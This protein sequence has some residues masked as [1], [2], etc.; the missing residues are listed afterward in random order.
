MI[1]FLGNDTEE[2]ARKIAEERSYGASGGPN[3]RG[4][5]T[6]VKVKDL[7]DEAFDEFSDAPYDFENTAQ[8]LWEDTQKVYYHACT[9]NRFTDKYLRLCGQLEKNIKELGSWCI[10]K[11]VL[12]H[13]GMVFPKLADMNI[14]E[15]VRMVSFHLRKVHAALEG[16]Y[17][18]NN[19]LGMAYLDWE[20]RWVSLG[21]R[22]KATEVKIQKIRDGRID[23]SDISDRWSVVGD[24][25]AVDGE[26]KAETGDR[27][28]KDFSRK[29]RSLRLNPMALPV[30]RS[31]VWELTRLRYEGRLQEN[32]QF[33]EQVRGSSEGLGLR[34]G[35]FEPQPFRPSPPIAP[36]RISPE[37]VIPEPEEIPEQPEAE[38]GM[39]TEAEARKILIERAMK[40]GDMK[41][42][43]EIQMEDLQTF[44]ARWMRHLEEQDM[45]YAMK[46]SGQT[47]PSNDTRK[48]LREKRKKRK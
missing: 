41:T 26:Q 9:A 39:L 15:L 20:L 27:K 14:D 43:M 46:K 2:M 24:Q 25:R 3:C 40:A 11:A 35:S 23:V 22:L 36:G 7:P 12:E 30:K 45:Q 44:H 19:L 38:S 17:Q 16:I 8:I 21:K 48:K 42:V 6:K 37:P 10:T 47:S 4:I 31:A 33:I 13:E 34:G 1:D 29:A 28:R 5:L 18:D 32:L